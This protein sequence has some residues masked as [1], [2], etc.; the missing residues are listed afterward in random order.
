MV[1][2]K[3]VYCHISPYQGLTAANADKWLAC[4]PGSEAAVAM[5]L[6]YLLIE[7][8][9]NGA[10]MAGQSPAKSLLDALWRLAESYP[11][12]KA[13]ALSGLSTDDLERLARLL[14]D[15]RQPLV[16]P[17]S[18]VGSGA[19]STAADLAVVWLNCFAQHPVAALRFQTAP[20]RGNGT[21]P[22]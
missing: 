2:N 9:R 21:Q 8:R 14:A 20:S 5:G 7:R 10:P 4:R 13:A 11:P 16:L 6:M 1:K 12:E 15:A 3:G 22:T 18:A 19:S 17:T